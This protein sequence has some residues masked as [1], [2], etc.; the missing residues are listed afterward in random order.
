MNI[1]KSHKKGQERK[2]NKAGKVKKSAAMRAAKVDAEKAKTEEEVIKDLRSLDDSLEKAYEEDGIKGIQSFLAGEECRKL[3]GSLEA[4]LKYDEQPMRGRF[5]C[6]GF[7]NTVDFQEAKGKNEVTQKILEVMQKELDEEGLSGLQ[8]FL[9]G[10]REIT[11]KYNVFLAIF[12]HKAFVYVKKRKVPLEGRD[13]INV[14]IS[15]QRK[16]KLED[17]I[18]ELKAA[19]QKKKFTSLSSFMV[20]ASCWTADW[21]KL[22]GVTLEEVFLAAAMYLK[23]KEETDKLQEKV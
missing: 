2:T 1:G 18:E 7:V 17:T 22:F 14:S 23:N 19:G 12:P 3:G 20:D 5:L 4:R 8:N 13:K 16:K 6:H 15:K 9:R 11:N 21:M 10:A